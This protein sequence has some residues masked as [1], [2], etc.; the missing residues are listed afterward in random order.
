MSSFHTIHDAA[1]YLC[2]VPP[3][4]IIPDGKIHRY[5]D[6]KVKGLPHW[7]LDY[8]GA[9]CIGTWKDGHAKANYNPS[10]TALTKKQQHELNA[11][12]ALTK[13]KQEREQKE[14]WAAGGR[15]AVATWNS[16]STSGTSEYLTVK[17]VGA[18]GV[19]FGGESSHLRGAKHK[20]GFIAVPL[21]QS[22]GGSIHSLQLIYDDHAT[23]DYMRGQGRNKTFI[24]DGRKAGCFHI[25]G[26]KGLLNP[27]N[28][29]IC[30]GYAT[31]ASI[32]MA[33]G[34]PVFVAF[35]CGN[36]KPVLERLV[37][38]YPTITF[39]L[40]ADNDC[41][42]EGNAGKMK[43]LEAAG[44]KHTVRLPRFRADSLLHQPTDFNDLHVLEGLDVV[45]H[46]INKC[47]KRAVPCGKHYYRFLRID[48]NY[49]LLFS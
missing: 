14:R 12:I 23:P 33:T 2:I 24:K 25:I 40:A 18:F 6:K 16:L 1:A 13:A 15:D 4:H 17:R 32:H 49:A 8:G 39:T 43:A 7:Y 45:R 47:R 11:Q 36:L 31:G 20:S 3:H 44:D 30:E 29:Y 35:D 19:R 46:A 28:V 22:V 34:L 5:T 9:G 10:S 27:R 21:R 42:K 38:L 26:S 48:R 37:T 41:W